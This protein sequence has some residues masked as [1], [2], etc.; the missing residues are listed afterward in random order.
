MKV[1]TNLDLTGLEIQ[2]VRAQNLATAP[3]TPL[4]GR[5]YYDTA[6]NK[7]TYWN[8]T[9]WINTDG[10]TIPDNTITSAKIVNGAILN[11]DINAAAAIALTKLATD[12]LARANHTGTQLAST[13]SDFNT[14]RDLQRLDQHAVPTASVNLNSQKITNLGAPTLDTDATT[15]LYVDAAINGLDWKL[16]VRVA[17]TANITLS[18]AQ[19]VD[20]VS[21]VAGD[22]VLVKNQTTGSANGLYLVAAGAW[23][24]T[25]DAD[26]NAE[27]TSGLATFVEE[28]TTN[29]NQQWV[30][31]TDNPITLGTT[32]LVFAQVGATGGA[33]TAGAGLTLISNTYDVG[34][35]TG[36]IVS[37]DAIAIDAA[38]VVRKV[39]ATV[40]DGAALFYVVT[41][42]LG[43]QWATVQVVRNTAPFDVVGADIELTDANTVT[44]RFAVAPT[45]A[46]Y[47]VIVTG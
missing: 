23:T 7:L 12:P 20:G 29:G 43:N 3:G 28:G 34:Q 27:V 9:A 32:A 16:S 44:V 46:A 10:S 45:V 35:G 22:R 1:L 39:T 18:G 4:V 47:R 6:T 31:N 15:K 13:I 36:I 40:G 17:T 30:L 42:N 26:S 2:N 25:T 14:A 24:R 19:T 38:V 8:G 41:H 37:A 21:L 33:P 5:F 11:E